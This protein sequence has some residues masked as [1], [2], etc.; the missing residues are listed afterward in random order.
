VARGTDVDDR[1]VVDHLERS[2]NA[3][4]A[5]RPSP[6]TPDTLGRIPPRGFTLLD[7]LG[8]LT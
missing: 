8:S 5:A 2:E 4:H 1:T 7:A 6:V 3:D